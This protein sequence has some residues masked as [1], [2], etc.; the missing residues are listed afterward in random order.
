MLSDILPKQKIFSKYIKG[1]KVDKFNP[2]LVK[3]VASHYEISRKEAK[4]RIE[5]YTH[6]ST[7]T[8]TLTEMLQG[9][10]KTKKEIKKL[11]K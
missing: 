11:L 7:G 2:E 9:Y 6:F 8:E 3:I 10:G 5:M 1:K 4:D